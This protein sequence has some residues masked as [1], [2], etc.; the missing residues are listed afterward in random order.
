MDFENCV[1][2][3]NADVWDSYISFMTSSQPYLRLNSQIQHMQ[4]YK[5]RFSKLTFHWSSRYLLALQDHIWHRL[6]DMIIEN[7]QDSAVY[8][9][10]LGVVSLA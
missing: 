1:D 6:R 3:G 8:C 5:I 9:D 7:I 2:S 10:L 4:Y